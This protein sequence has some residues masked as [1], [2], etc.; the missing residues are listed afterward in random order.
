LKAGIISLAERKELE[1]ISFSFEKSRQNGG[2][3]HSNT[4]NNSSLPIIARTTVESVVN[5]N[6]DQYQNSLKISRRQS[7]LT[8]DH[9]SMSPPQIS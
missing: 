5:K 6:S 4:L 8:D 1:A 9:S 7:V 2:L 3:N